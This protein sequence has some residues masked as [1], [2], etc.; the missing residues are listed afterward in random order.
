M[1]GPKIAVIGLGAAGSAALWQ[2]AR[3]GVAAIGIEQFALGHDHG[4]SHGATRVIRMVHFENPSYSVLMEHAYAQWRDIER[5]SKQQLLH[6]T[7]IIEIGSPSGDLVRGT[8]AG[9]TKGLAREHLDAQSVMRRYPAFRLP[10]KF[11]GV[12]QSD[13]GFIE[14]AAGLAAM[15]DLAKT[16]GAEIL[17]GTKVIEVIPTA[18]GVRIKTSRGDIAADGAIIAAGP[19]MRGFLSDLKLPLTVTRQVVGWFQPRD[20]ALF[21][22]GRFPVFIMETPHGN[23][24]G[25]P[26]HGDSGVKIAKHHHHN[27]L[28]DPDTYDRTV[29]AN[30]E[31]A[32]RAPLSQYLP[33]ANG[34]LRSAETCLYTMTPDDTFIIDRMPDYPHIAVASPC[35]GYG[36]KFSPVVGE[37]LA[38]LVAGG[39]TAHDISRFRLQRFA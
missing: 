4:S 31:A 1:A 11:V 7:G 36:F 17:T 33:D 24:Y 9:E 5:A 29:S 20:P 27:E 3:R 8:L 16:H 6:L 10:E 28:V 34:P 13:G 23:H 15:I 38:D 39:T 12:L 19:W 35:C 26:A 18:T 22:A 25:F 14:A 2:L 30:D 21:A 37:I 32:I